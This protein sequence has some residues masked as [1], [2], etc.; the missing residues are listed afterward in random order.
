MLSSCTTNA[1]RARPSQDALRCPNEIGMAGPGSAAVRL[2]APPAYRGP[3]AATQSHLIHVL[4]IR[5]QGPWCERPTMIRLLALVLC[6]SALAACSGSG[7]AGNFPFGWSSAPPRSGTPQ[8]RSEGRSGIK[9]DP[10]APN[11]PEPRGEE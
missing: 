10:Q 7:R 2:T 6:A 11:N 3:C 1:A 9:T 5:R 8:D 4:L